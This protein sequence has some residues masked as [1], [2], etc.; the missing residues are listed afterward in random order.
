MELK[1]KKKPQLLIDYAKMTQ[2]F[3]AELEA[4]KRAVL[5]P[6]PSESLQPRFQMP[7]NLLQQAL[8][9]HQAQLIR[10]QTIQF[11]T[12]QGLVEQMEL[13]YKV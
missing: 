2:R 4:K 10:A 11:Q 7:N 9:R 6:Q 8:K 1:L 13:T 12:E 5:Q 3:R